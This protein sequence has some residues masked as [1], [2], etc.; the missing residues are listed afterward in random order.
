M[1]S[2]LL[3]KKGI[4]GALSL[5]ML[6][7]GM[8]TEPGVIALNKE[9]IEEAVNTSAAETVPVTEMSTA[10][11]ATS[12]ISSLYLHDEEEKK[13][14]EIYRCSIKTGEEIS[15]KEILIESGCLKEEE[16]EDFLKPIKDVSVSDK[17]VL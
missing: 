12:D 2:T 14:N 3:I 17:E 1:L 10:S 6:L 5:N 16:I 9:G 4:Q 8:V 13:Q 7:G 15:L 11:D